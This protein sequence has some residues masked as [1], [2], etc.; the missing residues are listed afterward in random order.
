MT[1]LLVK[2]AIS[3]LLIAIISEVARR[4][5]GVAALIA[6]LPLV[7]LLAMIWMWRETGDAG[8]IADHAASTFWYVLPSMP[9][10][11][12]VPALLRAGIG[13]WLSLLLG[14]L[15]TVVLYA[16]LVWVAPRVGIRL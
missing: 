12:V 11:L 7:S 4:S 15:L 1:Y 3:G 14:C 5:A 2:A 6:S 13:F 8:R 10:F 9:M 16:G